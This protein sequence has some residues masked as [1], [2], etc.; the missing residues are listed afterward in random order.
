MNLSASIWYEF[1][2]NLTRDFLASGMAP[3]DA[4]NTAAHEACERER[5][6]ETVGMRAAISAKARRVRRADSAFVVRFSCRPDDVPDDRKAAA[7]ARGVLMDV[8]GTESAKDKS[9]ADEDSFAASIARGRLDLEAAYGEEVAKAAGVICVQLPTG[10]Q[11]FYFDYEKPE[12]APEMDGHLRNEGVNALIAQG[13]R[14]TGLN[15]H[16]PFNPV[17]ARRNGLDERR[18]TKRQKRRQRHQRRPL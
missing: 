7:L 10:T 13:A 12:G 8:A 17:P 5:L 18:R 14:V 6:S 9:A 11:R 16:D 2:L 15:G 4:V 3:Q 1:G